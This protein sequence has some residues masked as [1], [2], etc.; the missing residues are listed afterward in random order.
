MLLVIKQ[1][2]AHAI[3]SLT[4]DYPDEAA[5]AEHNQGIDNQSNQYFKL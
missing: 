1:A 5:N 4:E 3:K 2:L